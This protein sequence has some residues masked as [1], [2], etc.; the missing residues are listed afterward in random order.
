ML[1]KTLETPQK[2]SSSCVYVPE[3][4]TTFCGI[5]VR[6]RF[7]RRSVCE[8]VFVREK[9]IKRKKQLLLSFTHH[10][11]QNHLFQLQDRETRIS[12]SLFKSVE[13]VFNVIPFYE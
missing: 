2:L 12:V 7:L 5:T 6:E 4:K 3:V 8:R 1:V 10:A 11:L 13:F 9:H